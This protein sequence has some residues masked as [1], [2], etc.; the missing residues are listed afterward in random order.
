[1]RILDK[2]SL[3]IRAK[4][5]EKIRLRKPLRDALAEHLTTSGTVNPDHTSHRTRAR[6][7]DACRHMFVGEP[8]EEGMM[9]TA[10]SFPSV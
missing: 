9:S 7:T 3:E 8:Q 4:R 6:S 10:A 1:M 5:N 2:K